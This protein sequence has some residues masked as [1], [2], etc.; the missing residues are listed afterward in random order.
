MARPF[1]RRRKSCP[2]AAKDAP[3][4]DYKDVRLLQGFVS[5]RG[6]IVPL[7]HHR[8]LGQEAARAQPGHQARPPSGPAALHREVRS[9]PMEII[10]LERIEKLGAIGDVVNVKDGYARNYLLPNKKALRSNNANRKVFEANRARIEADNAAPPQRCR[11]RRQVGRRRAD[12]P[13]PPVVEQRP[14][15]RLGLGPRHRRGPARGAHKI[16]GKSMI[17][18]EPP[19]KTLGLFDVKVSLHPRSRSTS[20]STSPARRKRP[21]CRRPASTS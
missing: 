7:A 14:A 16:V 20:R 11:R 21:T 10:L 13:H 17:V 2:F 12:R 19:I 8:R 5:E 6:K 18:L 3:K 1:F 4:I 15:L 9:G